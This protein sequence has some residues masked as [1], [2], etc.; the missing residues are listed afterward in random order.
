MSTY[1][2]FPAAEVTPAA[3]G[4]VAA[5]L[6]ALPAVRNHGI[7]GTEMTKVFGQAH[8]PRKIPL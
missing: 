3:F 5:G 4:A 7:T 2:T 8:R 1:T 6:A